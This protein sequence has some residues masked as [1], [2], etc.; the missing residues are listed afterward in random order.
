MDDEDDTDTDNVT[1]D[2]GNIPGGAP[3]EPKPNP[4]ERKPEDKLFTQADV[5]RIVGSRIAKLKG[6]IDS[7]Q[8]QSDRLAEFEKAEEQRK[9]AELEKKGEYE[10]ATEALKQSFEQKLKAEQE[11]IGVVEGK[12]RHV[13]VDAELLAAAGSV[14]VNEEAAKDIARRLKDRCIVED[15]GDGMP[16]AVVVQEDGKTPCYKE[17][18]VP[19]TIKDLVESRREAWGYL[20][21]APDN[22]KL[23]GGGKKMPNTPQGAPVLPDQSQSLVGTGS[24]LE[25]LLQA[26]LQGSPSLVSSL[27]PGASTAT[28]I[29]A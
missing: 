11:K 16:H 13:V 8:S 4:D 10:K 24:N 25:A 6:E 19:M 15:S 22:A 5:D 23:G 2:Q 26:K 7:L 20:Y 18:G 12:L 1:T 17:G 27:L 21:K 9:K 29:G 3:G 14:A 28:R